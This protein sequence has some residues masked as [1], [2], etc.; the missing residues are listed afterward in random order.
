[1]CLGVQM[2]ELQMRRRR[3]TC[4]AQC[5]V[6]IVAVERPG[7]EILGE[8]AGFA[9]RAYCRNSSARSNPRTCGPRVR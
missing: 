2:L 6:E 8:T 5:L 1:V 7:Q 4:G 9:R 3:A